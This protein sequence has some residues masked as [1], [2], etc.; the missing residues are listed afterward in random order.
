M[1]LTGAFLRLDSMPWLGLVCIV[2]RRPF[3]FKGHMGTPFG[4]FDCH[5]TVGLVERARG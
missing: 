3:S 1:G 5:V 4:P 2:I